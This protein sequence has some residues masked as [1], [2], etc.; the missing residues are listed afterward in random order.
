MLKCSDFFECL[1]NEQIK[2]FA[3]VPDSLLKDFC[4]YIYN[5]VPTEKNVIAAN[6][7]NAVALAAGYHLATGNIGLVYMQNSGQ[8]N[9][10]NPLLSLADRE[11]Y[12]IPMLLLIGWRGEPGFHDEPQ[13]IKQGK[14]TQKI[15]EAMDLSYKVLSDEIESAKQDLELAISHCKKYSEPFALIVKKGTFDPYVSV[16]EN[17]TSHEMS[18]EEAIKMVVDSLNKR[19]VV[20]ST[21]GQ[22]SRELFEYREHLGTGHANDF[23]TVGS[24]G[25]SSQI[26]L[27]IALNKPSVNV[28]CIDGDGAVIM[29]MGGLAIVGQLGPEN[30]RHILI[31]NGAH[32]SVGGQPTAA[33]NMSIPDIARSCGY[34]NVYSVKSK[35]DLNR[36]LKEFNDSK[37]PSFLEIIVN[38]GARKNLG[39][40]TSTP[41]ENKDSFMNYLKEN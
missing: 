1:T 35:S 22:T 11:V 24:M 25:H 26:A 31:N 6:E 21:T 32:D 9:S 18:R 12:G 33:N 7:G 38:K 27:G 34:R 17:P 29:H 10:L 28:Y 36:I 15:F 8:G 16:N 23:L 20:V 4:A 30:F 19:D 13:H 40:P 41:Q 39:R 37:G 5:V 3:G 14:V 2:F